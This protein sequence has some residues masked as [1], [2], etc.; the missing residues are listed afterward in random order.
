MVV[1]SN[2]K[3]KVSLSKDAYIDKVISGAMIG[4]TKDEANKEIRKQYGFKANQGIGYIETEV[5]TKELYEALI[6]G[7]VMCHLFNP[8][9][10]RKDGTFGSSEKK[11]DNFVGSYVIGVDID[12]TNFD[13]M[14]SFIDA[15]SIKPTFGYTTYSNGVKGVRFR[16]MYVMD[17]I[18][19]NK[20]DFRYAAWKLYQIIESD[21]NEEIS[22][23]CGLKCSQYFNGTN[24]DNEELVFSS[25][26]SGLIYNQ[27][28]LGCSLEDYTNFVENYFYFKTKT[29]KVKE[30]K[31]SILS[32]LKYINSISTT[33]YNDCQK[34]E[35]QENE[36]EVEINP[37]IQEPLE[38]P[39]VECSESLINDMIRLPYDEF[40]KY[41]RHKYRYFYRKEREEWNTLEDGIEW[42][43]TDDSYFCLF[44]NVHKVKDGSQRRKKLYQRMCLRRV[45][46]PEVDADTLLFNAYED[47]HRFFENDFEKVGNVITIDELVKNVYWA[48]DKSIED[49]EDDF[50]ENIEYLK[51]KAPKRIYKFKGIITVG[52]RN[53]LIKKIL[54]SQIGELYDISLSPKDNLDNLKKYDIN[55]SLRTIYR[56]CEENKINTKQSKQDL[57][58]K[59]LMIYDKSLSLRKNLDIIKSKG[60]KISLGKLSYLV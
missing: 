1:N 31:E 16:L 52:E 44:Y 2:F 36:V 7:K 28:E 6:S 26:Y 5:T 29:K 15:L 49:I 55:V 39:K 43:D 20:Y 40:M 12:D 60:Y 54:W 17:E 57:D 23:K 24:K 58:S 32:N 45:I 25:Y 11:D 41:N 53:S 34:I 50:S 22:D 8:T 56:F 13:S 27:E 14:E 9:K 47:L 4:T 51:S 21:T 48:L 10:V 30:D 38:E 37:I 59:I 33:Y 18:I 3:F 46:N 35:H 19:I 42:Q